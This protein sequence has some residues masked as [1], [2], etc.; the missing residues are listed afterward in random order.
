MKICTILFWHIKARAAG[1]EGIGWKRGLVSY[2][3]QLH[4]T[5]VP[6]LYSVHATK[7]GLSL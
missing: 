4:F 3:H 1:L 6:H 5:R 7:L 2:I